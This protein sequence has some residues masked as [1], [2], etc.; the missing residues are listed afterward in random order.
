[1][2]IEK[3]EEPVAVLPERQRVTG[4]ML[5]AILRGD[6]VE[7]TQVLQILG[8]RSGNAQEK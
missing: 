2:L 8:E 7:R 3:S 4:T 1:V 5:A 6:I